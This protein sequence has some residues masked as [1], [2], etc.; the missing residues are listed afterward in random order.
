MNLTGRD[1]VFSEWVSG[2]SQGALVGPDASVVGSGGVL[3]VV[4]CV[5][6]LPRVAIQLPARPR[7]YMVS[8]TQ[9]AQ[10]RSW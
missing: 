8:P 4:D 2:F 5:R 9:V 1:E 6:S 10:P 7:L 3:A